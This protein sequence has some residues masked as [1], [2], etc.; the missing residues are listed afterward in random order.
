VQSTR[1]RQGVRA[2]AVWDERGLLR[3]YPLVEPA[4]H[5]YR[6]MTRSDWMPCLV[7]ERI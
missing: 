4:T 2:V 3:A 7:G 1:I 6:I 5:Y